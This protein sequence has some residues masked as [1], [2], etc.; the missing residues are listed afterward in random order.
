M[1]LGEI[2]HPRWMARAACNGVDG[3]LF[4]AFE[5]EDWAMARYRLA[6]AKAICRQCPVIQECLAYAE[7]NRCPW[8]VWGGLDERERDKLF[9][10]RPG[11]AARYKPS[12]IGLD[13]EEAA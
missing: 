5:G 4:F 10:R 7:V 12:D 13:I 6:E 2:A 8:G 1:D 11:G 3:D 9:H